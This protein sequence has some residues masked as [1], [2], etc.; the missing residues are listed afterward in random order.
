MSDK[1]INNTFGRNLI[2]TLVPVLISGLTYFMLTTHGLDKRV[3]ILEQQ[4]KDVTSKR[5]Y[6]IEKDIAIIQ[7]CGDVG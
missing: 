6:E 1:E 7:R 4:L 5:I 2:L 3:L